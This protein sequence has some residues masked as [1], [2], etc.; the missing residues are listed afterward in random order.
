MLLLAACAPVALTAARGTPTLDGELHE[1][2]WRATPTTGPWK[3]DG[4]VAFTEGPNK[5]KTWPVLYAL[6]GDTLRICGGE[7]GKGRP[8]DF[9]TRGKPGSLLMTLRRE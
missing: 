3:G 8:A 4:I 9:E 5:G 7:V 2:Q 6:E 1:P